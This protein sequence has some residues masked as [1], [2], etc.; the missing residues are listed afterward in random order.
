MGPSLQDHN[1]FWSWTAATQRPARWPCC[2]AMRLMC[3]ITCRMHDIVARHVRKW[4]LSLACD[5]RQTVSRAIVVD[6]TADHHSQQ[7][8]SFEGQRIRSLTF[9]RSREPIQRAWSL[10]AA[11]GAVLLSSRSH[12]LSRVPTACQTSLCFFEQTCSVDGPFARL[13]SLVLGL[14]SN[15]GVLDAARARRVCAQKTGNC[16]LSAFARSPRRGRRL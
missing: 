6:L 16:I 3:R 13:C 9:T 7:F 10:Q 14:F 5:Q 1:F 12:R 2:S 15:C 11:T 4:R 8:A